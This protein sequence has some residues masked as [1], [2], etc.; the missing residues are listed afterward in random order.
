MTCPPYPPRPGGG[1]VPSRPVARGAFI[2]SSAP[3][4]A[5]KTL[6]AAAH[7]GAAEW[8]FVCHSES[9]AREAERRAKNLL[10]VPADPSPSAQDDNLN[11]PPPGKRGVSL[12]SGIC[13]EL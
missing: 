9:G 3:G 11:P 6:G 12:K 7:G 4:C 10:F 2:G 13:V 5:A 1:T 8:F